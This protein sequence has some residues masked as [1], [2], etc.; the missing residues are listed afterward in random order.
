MATSTP[1]RLTSGEIHPEN[2]NTDGCP[3]F[4]DTESI[5]QDKHQIK[6]VPKGS[7]QS[8]KV[9][10][11]ETDRVLPRDDL[12]K[13][14]ASIWLEF[15][16]ASEISIHCDFF[17]LG[18]SSLLAVGIVSRISDE[19]NLDLP[20]RDF[21]ANP[22]ITTQARHIRQLLE[23]DNDSVETDNL[24]QESI[25][26]RNRLPQIQPVYFDCQKERL[27]GM[28]YKP[29]QNQES[30]SHAVL[31]CHPL[32]HEY[33]RSYRNLQQFSLHLTKAGFDIFR[34]DYAGTGNSSGKP[35]EAETSD[36]IQN[37]N[38]AAQYI[39]QKSQSKKLSVIAVRMGAPLVVQADIDELENLILW[40][41]VVSGS[42]YISLLHE[43]H[44]AALSKLERYRVK[45]KV[46]A[47]PQLF[48]FATSQS[49]ESDLNKLVMP[50]FETNDARITSVN[51]T[52]LVTSASYPDNEPEVAHLAKQCRHFS[53][54]DEIQ[55]H[56]RL[57]TESAFSSPEAFQVMMDV[58]KGE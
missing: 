33:S 7:R 14:L 8:K 11:V 21:F 47:L 54:K 4:V 43:F 45:R 20:V 6:A 12:E 19:F 16:S 28:H 29:R 26:L 48:G 39:R 44:N 36:Y 49:Q 24:D 56:D 5:D 41:P 58:L 2:I 35:E 51:A 9:A 46:S 27:F 55:W 10:L 3:T 25:D 13:R 30:R 38:T 52:V 53:T 22:T 15:L 57:Y 1:I 42:N 23:I 50:E 31:I 37:I 32:G 34:F 17:A 40:D 18:G